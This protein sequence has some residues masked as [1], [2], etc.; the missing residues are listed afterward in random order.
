VGVGQPASLAIDPSATVALLPSG[1]LPVGLAPAAACEPSALPF[2]GVGQPAS[3]TAVGRLMEPDDPRASLDSID[4]LF[5][6]ASI[7]FGVGHPISPVS[8]LGCADARSREN[9]RPEGVT[10]SFQVSRHKVEPSPASRAF[11]LFSKDKVRA[12]LA[13]EPVE[14]WPKVP[15]V[16]KPAA[17]ACRAERLAWARSGPERTIGGDASL[18]QGKG[19]SADSG[20]EVALSKSSKFVWRNVFYAPLVN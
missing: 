16:S 1:R 18:S 14:G 20:K 6:V 13:D 8:D 17:F 11:N 7:D 3:S 4:S 15:L 19:P 5:D 12:T 9:R 10:A 2:V